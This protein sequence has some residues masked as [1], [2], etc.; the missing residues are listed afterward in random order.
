ML[1]DLNE[2][3]DG[4]I[5]TGN[6]MA[7][8]AC[9]NCA[10]CHACCEQMGESIVLDPLDI[11]RLCAVTGKNFEELLQRELELHVVE[12]LI[13]PNLAMIG[14]NE[15]CAFLDEAG[16]CSIH[17]NRPGLC[18]VFPL[19]RI[20]EEGEIRYFLQSD[21]CQKPERT[22]LKISK[23][24]DTPE[25]KKNEQFLLR[26]HRLRKDMQ[27]RIA[28][29]ADEQ[30]AKTINMFLLNHFF[31][32]PYDTTKDFYEQFEMRMQQAQRVL[33]IE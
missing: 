7:R 17:A 32:T 2:I 26:W 8:V 3:S 19:G 20:Y 12:G 13:L 29:E 10:G 5:Y 4:R 6:D 1:Q 31:V 18:R 25:P 16:R 27:E 24:L 21:A 33:G 30:M 9:Q 14:K 11:W 15:Q 23:W 22:K 28:G